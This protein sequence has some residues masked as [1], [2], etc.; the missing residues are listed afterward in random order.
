MA[1]ILDTVRNVDVMDLAGRVIAEPERCRVS[2]AE[3]LTLALSVEA[4]W[5]ICLEA[6][7]F[8]TALDRLADATPTE[9]PALRDKL[10][11]HAAEVQ[12]RMRV[13]RQ[14]N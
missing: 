12:R 10:T 1:D 8:V 5:G 6:E 9:R 4:L 11:N 13:M 14:P 7:A 2:T 3:Q